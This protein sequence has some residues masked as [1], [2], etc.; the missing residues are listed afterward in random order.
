[1]HRN[2][3]SARERALRARLAQ[4]AHALPL[5]RATLNERRLTCGKKGCRC[6]GG[7]K[8]RA[9]Y[10]VS[11]REGKTRQVF[12]SREREAAVRQW[13]DNFHKV[14]GLLDELSELFWEQVRSKKS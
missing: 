4:M 2:H 10:A 3:M 13:V 1:M 5:L 14:H 9:L 7:E 11:A 12:V 6:H 8:H